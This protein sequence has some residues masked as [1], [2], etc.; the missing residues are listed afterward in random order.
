VSIACKLNQIPIQKDLKL[1][2]LTS[3]VLKP[4][5]RHTPSREIPHHLK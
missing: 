2:S 4:I 3:N 5:T 1:V